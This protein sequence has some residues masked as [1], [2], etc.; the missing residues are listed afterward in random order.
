MSLERVIKALIS[1]GLSRSDAEIYV[2]IAKKERPQKVVD[3][4]RGLNYSIYQIDSSLKSLINKELVMKDGSTFYALPFEET[5]ELLIKKEK[6]KA[7]SIEKSKEKLLVNW[8][9]EN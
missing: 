7:K 8:K 5:L 1:L 9:R 6:E 4:G 2:F 3:L